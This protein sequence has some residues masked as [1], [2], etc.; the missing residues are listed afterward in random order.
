MKTCTHCKLE[1]PFSDFGFKNKAKGYYQPICRACR[2]TLDSQLYKTSD[3][4]KESV[5]AAVQRNQVKHREYVWRYLETH[6]CVECGETD[7]RVLEFDHLD[8]STK[9][10]AVSTI[11]SYCSKKRIDEEIAKCRVLCCNC[12]RR[13]TFDQL[14]W[15]TF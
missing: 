11:A 10:G 3:K 1:K 9:T 13:H 14:G 15:M 12:H 4:R 5:K 7:P 6:P 2:K 8:R